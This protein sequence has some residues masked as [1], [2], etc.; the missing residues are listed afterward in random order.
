MDAFITHLDPEIVQPGDLVA[1]SLP[2]NL[3][4]E[5]CERGGRYLNLSLQLP[6]NLRGVELS[7][8]QMRA[9]GACLEEY[10]VIRLDGLTVALWIPLGPLRRGP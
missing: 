9:C 2:V 4:A 6:A 8:E 7:V 5:V 1:G 3:A 10:R